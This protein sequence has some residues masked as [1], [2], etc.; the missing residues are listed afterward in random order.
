MNL[1]SIFH[2][3]TTVKGDSA[4]YVYLLQFTDGTEKQIQ[5]SLPISL[6]IRFR[7]LS[8]IAIYQC[9][10][11]DSLDLDSLLR[12]YYALLK[13][14]CY[15]QTTVLEAEANLGTYLASL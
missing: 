14:E 11:K 8:T 9:A 2:R 7:W 12:D 3:Q 4:N 10:T 15:S 5:F 13:K 6:A 1:L